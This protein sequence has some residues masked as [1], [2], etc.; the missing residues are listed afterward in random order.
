MMTKKEK[1]IACIGNIKPSRIH[2][3]AGCSREY[4]FKVYQW[5]QTNEKNNI[6]YQ[7][8]QHLNPVG[9]IKG[10]NASGYAGCMRNGNIVDRREFPNAIAIREN[11]LLGVA[12]PKEL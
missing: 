11:S 6:F 2:L 3:L 12:K 4:A 1:I 8:N 7:K 9:W 10:L 5:Y